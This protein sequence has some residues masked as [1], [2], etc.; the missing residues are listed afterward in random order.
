M[1]QEDTPRQGEDG[2]IDFSRY[3]VAQLSELKSLI[4]PVS[5]PLDHDHLQEEIARR[6]GTDYLWTGRFTSADGI[7]GWIT[8]IRERQPLYGEAAIEL[9]PDGLILHG[10]RRT[11]LGI[12]TQASVRVPFD[13]IRNVVRDGANIWFN[14]GR[15]SRVCFQ[16]VSPAA[17]TALTDVLP[18]FQTNGFERKW[19]ATRQFNLKLAAGGRYAWVTLA[20]ALLNIGVFA[21]QSWQAQQLGEFSINNIMNWGGNYGPL[22]VSGEWWRLVTYAFLHMDLWHLLINLWALTGIGR[23]T[24]RLYGRW[25]YAGLYLVLAAIAGMVSLSWHPSVVSIGAS[26][27]IYGVFGLFLGYLGRHFRRVPVSLIWAHWPS[28]LVFVIFSL[29]NGMQQSG[30]DNAAHVG[31]LLGGLLL[32]LVAAPRLDENGPARWSLSRM[33][34][35]TSLAAATLV[36]GYAHTR[37][38]DL[39]LAPWEKYIQAR[40]WFSD[41][42]GRNDQRWGEL[43]QSLGIGEASNLVVADAFEKEVIPF[44][45]DAESRLERE[46]AGVTGDYVQFSAVMRELI[47]SR[48]EM[49]EALVRVLRSSNPDEEEL[50]EKSNKLMTVMAHMQVFQLRAAASHH[51]GSLANNTVMDYLSRRLFGGEP[52]C[53]EPPEVFH[54]QASGE[55]NPKDGP[56]RWAA[57][58]CEAQ[59]LFLEADYE[60][61]EALFNASAAKL[62][63]LPD[64]SSSID[65]ASTGLSNLFEFGEITIDDAFGRLV[66]WADKY[67][68]SMSAMLMQAQFLE[69]WAWAARGHGVANAV[70]AQAAALFSIRSQMANAV[71]EEIKEQAAGHPR[72]YSQAMRVQL[73][74]S[75]KDEVF[76]LFR[77]GSARF[78]TYYALHRQVLRSMM[79]R[80]GGSHGA[81]HIFIN[82]EV[83]SVPEEQKKELYARLFWSYRNLENDDLDLIRKVGM[84]WGIVREGMRG[85]IDHHPDSDYWLNAATSFACHVDDDNEYKRLRPLLQGRMSF[86]AWRKNETVEDCDAKFAKAKMEPQDEP[87]A[88]ESEI[89]E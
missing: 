22:T 62:G 29:L 79:P 57:T 12:A 37:N 75:N 70:P 24:E 53:V 82:K 44:W 41:G 35:V 88:Q 40:A 13:R 77:A 49:A 65:A 71:L 38:S 32:G 19:R 48:R 6:N 34:I 9:A 83:E 26:G 68:Q 50:S 25:R 81:V 7:L 51:P 18:S 2:S 20:L 17:A 42:A 16:A 27:A 1:D 45:V 31:G 89:E 39:G 76:D 69:D 10:W 21:A 54:Q 5:R 55:D 36:A 14:C 78:P 67:P 56:A 72:W 47:Q 58:A 73:S 61:L 15:F 8:A 52:T 74:I 23:L 11:W 63:D 28:T 84:R 30:V 60:A 66:T 33:G 80:W 87:D 85:L 86:S 46:D 59:R 64:G 43:A 4:D 3:T